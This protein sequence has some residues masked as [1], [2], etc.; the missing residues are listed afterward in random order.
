[1]YDLFS[2]YK[3]NSE[4][5]TVHVSRLLEL[6]QAFGKNPSQADC[7]RRIDELE[8]DEKFELTFEDFLQLI[9]ESWTSVN[10]DRTTLRNALEKFDHSKEGFIDIEQFRIAMRTLGEPLSDDEIDGL[11][12]LGLNDEHRKID[13]ECKDGFLKMN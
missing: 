10:N 12:Q 5:D 8:S 2:K 7:Q 6:L 3:D 1:M 13:I 11:I 4:L 9:D